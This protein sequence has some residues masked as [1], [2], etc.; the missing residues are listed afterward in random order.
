MSVRHGGGARL[1][2]RSVLLGGAGALL[3]AACGGGDDDSGESSDDR[4]T[5]TT[6]GGLAIARV[7][8]PRQP[9]GKP[10]RLPLALA[11]ADGA[12]LAAEH[13]PSSIEV[14]W[15]AD[16]SEPGTPVTIERR[17]E[18]IPTPYF[19]LTVT[20]DAPGT[21]RIDIDADGERAAT[22]V[23]VLPP[24]QT[25]A[26]PGPGDAL[27]SLV[28]PTTGDAR[29]VDPICTRD[30]DCPFH[31]ESLDAA[32]ASPKAIAL[33]VS[34]PAFCQTAICGPVLDLLVDRAEQHAEVLS[35]V[36]AEVYTDETAKT[37]TE[38]VQAYGMTYEPALFL[39]AADGTINARLDYTFDGSELDEV[40]SRLVQ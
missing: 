19:P 12:I 26:V 29:G 32:L 5:T 30:P 3:L 24:E 4:S 35:I 20:F 39:A 6:A 14:T 23:D 10:L 31:T 8:Y 27:L 13:T 2:R 36:H 21:Y 37:T 33:I 22:T 17:A 1:T 11:S 34:T 18:G 15:Y 7:F 9:A 16:G 25:P 40:L 38:T 28:T